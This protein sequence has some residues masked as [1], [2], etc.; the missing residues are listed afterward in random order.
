MTE[1]RGRLSVS[2]GAPGTWVLRAAVRA[3]KDAVRAWAIVPHVYRKTA[4]RR[5]KS[6]GLSIRSRRRFRRREVLRMKLRAALGVLVA[7]FKIALAR[8]VVIT[9]YPNEGLLANI[10][11]VLEVVHRVR[12]GAHV[13][14]D[15][16]LSGAEL[17]FRYG[18]KGDDVWVRLFRATGA[19]SAAAV[20]AA[21]RLDLA[22]WGTGKDHLTGRRLKKQ[23]EVYHSTLLKWVEIT[24]ERVLAQVNEICTRHFH[25]RFCIG[26][27]RRVGN[28]MVADLQADGKVPSLES[29]VRTVE[30]IISVATNNGT[31]GYAVYLATDDAE[32][33][34]ALRSAFGQKL[35][36]RENVQRTT[37]DGTEVH[38]RDWDQVSTTDAEDALIDAVLLS[39]CNVMVHTSSSVSTVASIMNPALLLVRA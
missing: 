24:N 39:Q 3:A 7:S 25:G 33:V 12:P 38:F 37:A 18:R 36:V 19:P 16:T 27:H 22:F 1:A 14:V 13:H 5:T 15:W 20:Q 30:S 17:A 26:V 4:Y 6:G 9:R 34:G 29:I 31:R 8:D 28:A 21:A 2:A 23:R 35:I 10:L 11:H 32:A